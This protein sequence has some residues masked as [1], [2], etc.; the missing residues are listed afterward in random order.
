MT[1]TEWRS[2][3]GNL[4][5]KKAKGV[6][7]L[8]VRLY[9]PTRVTL[10]SLTHK[11][12]RNP[13]GMFN[14]SHPFAKLY[15]LIDEAGNQAARWGTTRVVDDD[16]NPTWGESFTIDF[17]GRLPRGGRLS[18]LKIIVLDYD[19]GSAISSADVD[20]L[21]KVT[22]PWTDAFATEPRRVS[23]SLKY[24]GS[25]AGKVDVT[26]EALAGNDDGAPTPAQPTSTSAD[27]AEARIR[28]LEAQLRIRE[29]EAQLAA[30]TMGQPAASPS[31]SPPLARPA[32]P[33]G[34]YPPMATPVAQPATPAP[35]LMRVQVPAGC[36]PGSPLIVAAPSG[37][38]LQVTVPHGVHQGMFFQVEIPS[39]LQNV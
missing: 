18:P 23:L 36:A 15:G 22:V 13:D 1:S 17:E 10:N 34:Q 30:A 7:E 28:E 25:K 5:G 27:D 24:K 26:F 8:A 3:K 6:L 20:T 35:Q 38:Q 33:A 21:G 29:L 37:Q 4:E 14:K 11:G 31:A 32:Q 39:H 9:T 16:L 19:K 2:V 12:L